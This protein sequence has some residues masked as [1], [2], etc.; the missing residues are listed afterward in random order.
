MNSGIAL[1]TLAHSLHE[2]VEFVCNK[3]GEPTS[4]GA[5]LCVA[6]G[7][8]MEPSLTFA[9][10]VEKLQ[11]PPYPEYTEEVNV[12]RVAIS[13]ELEANES[14][15]LPVF[16]PQSQV[17]EQTQYGHIIYQKA[18]LLSGSEIQEHTGKSA[19]SLGLTPFETRFE[20][21]GNATNFYTVSLNDLPE[22]MAKSVKKV[23]VFHSVVAVSDQLL[24]NPTMQL[25]KN[26]F[27]PV[28][29]HAVHKYQEKSPGLKKGL[30]TLPELQELAGLIDEELQGHL[31]AKETVET[32]DASA[33]KRAKA[34]A[35]LDGIDNAPPKAATSAA[36]KRRRVNNTTNTSAAQQLPAIADAEST[37]SPLLALQ[38][39]AQAAQAEALAPA[40]PSPPDDRSSKRS[41]ADSAKSKKLLAELEAM[42]AEMRR[43]AELHC[44]T[45]R[46]ASAKSLAGLTPAKFMHVGMNHEKSHSLV[47]ATRLRLCSFNTDW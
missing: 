4:W 25:S 37:R 31:E 20:S 2:E 6:T 43:V 12:A 15:T 5:V 29:D 19:E 40:A 9:Q 22:N 45:S 24:L 44:S 35:G 47:N 18:A 39:A 21:P 38:Q 42:D 30:K 8:R 34:L 33:P 13:E 17:G 41:V 26:Q 1:L 27:V 11:N 16:V 28:F 7:K 10:F 36:A 32:S 3:A 46:T 23:K 14:R